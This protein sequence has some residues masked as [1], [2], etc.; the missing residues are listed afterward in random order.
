MEET[1]PVV[2]VDY[3]SMS[4]RGTA[5]GVNDR[6]KGVQLGTDNGNPF[7]VGMAFLEI[8]IH[9]RVVAKM[10][11]Q[12]QFGRETLQHAAGM[13]VGATRS[14]AIGHIHSHTHFETQFRHGIYLD[15]AAPRTD[16]REHVVPIVDRGVIIDSDGAV[17]V[18]RIG[19]TAATVHRM[20]PI[21]HHLGRGG[22]DAACKRS[23]VSRRVE[24]AT[25]VVRF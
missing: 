13:L 9:S 21:A 7:L 20:A 25:V 4:T 1:V 23:L 3:K 10:V 5:A 8:G 18:R 24:R 16:Y 14:R 22:S 19:M 6:T 15:L 17:S 2:T 12:S 11:F